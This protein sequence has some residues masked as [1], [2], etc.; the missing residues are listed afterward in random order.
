M[1]A[2]KLKEV[3]SKFE[4]EEGEYKVAKEDELGESEFVFVIVDKKSPRKYL[5]ANSWRHPGIEE[6]ANYYRE[7]GYPVKKPIPRKISTLEVPEDKD[8]SFWV[9]LYSAYTV[10]EM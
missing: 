3:L 2:D 6:E 5:I 10:F 7:N 9:Y 1:D 8:D 4:V